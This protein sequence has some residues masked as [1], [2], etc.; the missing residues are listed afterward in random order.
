MVPPWEPGI[1]ARGGWAWV[2]KAA[3]EFWANETTLHEPQSV[4]RKKKKKK[5]THTG[6]PGGS[7]VKN[8]P[9]KA[10]NIDLTPGLGRSPLPQ[11]NWA[12][13]PQLLSLFSRTR[14]PQLLKPLSLRD[15]AP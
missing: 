15:L 8:P 11:C 1:Q 5:M 14:E 12:H 4:K 2:H 3:L 10:G 13:M 6:F 9:A 7:V